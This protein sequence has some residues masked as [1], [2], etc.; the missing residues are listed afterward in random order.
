[1]LICHF[2]STG[3][4]ADNLIYVFVALSKFEALIKQ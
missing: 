1:M 4:R 3:P 2:L